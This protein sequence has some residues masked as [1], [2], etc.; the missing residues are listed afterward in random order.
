MAFA[1]DDLLAGKAVDVA[2]KG[3]RGAYR[4]FG[5]QDA[6]GRLLVLLHADFGKEAEL[7]RDAFYGWRKHASLIDVFE[8]VLTGEMLRSPDAVGEL[9]DLIRPRLVRTAPECVDEL[10]RRVA[11]AV[12]RAAPLVVDGGTPETQLV[13]AHIAD[14]RQRVAPQPKLGP[15][16]VRFQ[17]PLPSTYFVGREAELQALDRLLGGTERAAVTQ[18]IAGLGGVGKSQLAARYVFDHAD[19]YD[20]VA[21]I[22]VQDGGVADL[23]R[24]A[25]YV[26][27]VDA[28]TTADARAEATLG[29]LA[30][31]QE[32]W[33]L[34][35]DN[36][37]DAAQLAGCC[38]SSGNGRVLI[39]TRDQRVGQYAAMLPI[40]VF[41]EA[42]AIDYLVSR[43]R[44]PAERSA[45]QRVAAALG[46]LPLALAHAG[47][48][49]E[50]GASFDE[51]LDLLDALPPRELFDSSPEAFYRDT[52]A[53][54][55][56]ASVRAAAEHAPFATRGAGNGVLPSA[57]CHPPSVV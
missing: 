5:E 54:T 21:W 11:E 47:A 43:T 50:Q 19:E 31:C 45:A 26:L 4:A 3:I 29:W 1:I 53:S 34:V 46:C 41:D 38:P 20:V 6:I 8:R 56:Q 10:A 14:V 44:R 30:A 52:V 42:T 39:T 7:G 37:T 23:A 51:Y 33:L 18:A 40:D 35:L 32:R 48:Y 22:H 13:L 55:W 24:L 27:D 25:G 2:L 49:C 9:A 57:R 17:L 12:F 28:Q 15:R 36:V 16:H